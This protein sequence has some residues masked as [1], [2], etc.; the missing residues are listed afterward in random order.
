[1][2]EIRCRVRRL[3]DDAQAK[4]EFCGAAYPCDGCI[5]RLL[6]EQDDRYC[7]AFAQWF[8]RAFDLAAARLRRAVR[9]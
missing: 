3:Q 6:C 4:T 8:R 5:R 7:L 9:R 1:M 2:R